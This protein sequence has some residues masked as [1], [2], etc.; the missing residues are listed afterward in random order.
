LHQAVT[1]TFGTPSYSL[2]FSNFA[3]NYS[4]SGAGDISNTASLTLNGTANV[5]LSGANTPYIAAL[6]VNAGSLYLNTPAENGASVTVNSGGTLGGSASVTAPVTVASGG[7]LVAG[8]GAGAGALT[9]SS[10]ALGASGTDA[11]T[12]NLVGNA[13]GL[14]TSFA[15]TTANGFANKGITTINVSGTLPGVTATN[16]N[17][18][19]YSG[20]VGGSG[21]FVLGSIPAFQTTAYLSNNVAASAIQLVIPPPSVTWVGAPTNNWDLSGTND[22]LVSSVG[23][24]S[25]GV[26][27]SYTNGD[28]VIF[29]DTA[30]NFSVNL[31]AMVKPFSVTFSNSLNNY[32]VTGAGSVTNV[33]SFNMN[34]AATTTFNGTNLYF[35]NLTVNAG[36]LYLN[37]LTNSG[38]TVTVNSGATLAGNGTISATVMKVA[39]GGALMAGSNAGSGT[40]IMKNLTLGAAATDALTLNLN[41]TTGGLSGT[42]TVTGSSTL[43]NNGVTTINI[44]GALPATYPATY[45]VVTYAGTTKGSGTFVLGTVPSTLSTPYLTNNAAALAIQLVVPQPSLTW[46]GTPTNNW[47]LTG[48]NVW[49]QTYSG[50]PAYFTNGSPVVF[51]DTAAS[52]SV[53][54]AGVVQPYSVVFSNSA[55]NYNFT[56]AGNVSNALSFTQMRAGTVTFGGAKIYNSFLTI[57]AGTLYLNTT[58]TGGTV[59][60]NRGG[61]LGGS[62]LIGAPVTVANGGALVAGNSA[63]AGILAMKSLVLG[64]SASDALTLNL[65]STATGLASSFTVT[66]SSG[67]TNNGIATINITGALPTNNPATY[68]LVTY[69][70]SVKGSGT[71]VLGSFP[72]AI[73][74]PYLTNNAS[75][76]AIQLVVPAY[77]APALTWVGSPTNDWDLAGSLDWVLTG[78]STPASYVDVSPLLFDDTATNFSVNLAGTV[79]PYT[80]VFT[81]FL[82]NYTVGGAGGIA[83]AVSLVK[84]GTATVTLATTNSYTG[85]TTVAAGTLALGSSAAIPSGPTAGNVVVNGTLDLAGNSPVVNNLS[86]SGTV[87]NLSAGGNPVLTVSNIANSSFS[88]VIQNSSGSVALAKT[89]PGTLT[90]A[91]NSTYNGG[92]TI[93]NG[94]VSI[95]GAGG[96]G[97]GPVTVTENTAGGVSNILTVATTSAVVLTNNFILPNASGTN[98]LTKN[99]TGRLTLGGTL[100]GGGSGMIL[101][102]STDTLLDTNTVTEFA[103]TNSFAG[104]VQLWRG[105]VQVDNPSSLGSATI[106]GNGNASTNGDLSFANSMTFANPLVMQA[107]TTVSPNTN[108]VVMSGAISGNYN[109]TKYGSGALTLAGANTYSGILT[110][111]AGTLAVGSVTLAADTTDSSQTNFISIAAGAVVQSSGNL[112]LDASTTI[113]PSIVVSGAGTLQLTATNNGPTSPDIYFNATDVPNSTANWGTRIATPVNLG[114]VQRYIWGN[115]EHASVDK[116]GVN[117]GD[118]QFNGTISGT[119]GL[120]FIAQ[121]SFTGANPMETPFCL[122]AANNFTGPVQIQRGSIYLGAAGAYPAGNVL[123][124]NV[125]AGNFGKLYLFGQNATV[126]DLSSTGAGGAFIANGCRN[127]S[128]IGP[129]TLTIIQNNPGTFTGSLVDTNLE[130][131]GTAVN[132][133]TILNVVKTGP[134]ALTL[135]GNHSFSGTLAVNAGKLYINGLS[136]GGGSVTVSNGA[137]LGGL[138]TITS[139]VT[140]SNAATLEAGGGLGFGALSLNKLTLGAQVSDAITLNCDAIPAGINEVSVQNANGLINN[141]TVTVNVTGVL[142][143]S[144]P[145]VYTLIAYAGTIQGAGSFVLGSVPDQ[146]VAYITNNTAAAA[147]Q[148]VVSSLTIPSVTWTGSPTNDWDLL[149]NN[150]WIQTGTSV[151]AAYADFDQVVFDDTATNFTVNL[152]AAVSPNGVTFSNNVNNYVINGSGAISGYSALTM[153]GT[154]SVTLATTNSYLGA[155]TIGAGTVVLGVS[156]AIPGGPGAGNL[157]VNGTLDVGGFS[158][159]FNNLSGAGVV[160]NVSAGGSPVLTVSN[161]AASVFAG[162]LQNTTGSLALNQTGSGTLVLA[163]NNTY[164]GITT[165]NSGAVQIGNGGASG[166]LGAGPVLDNGTLILDRSDLY[167][168]PNNIAGAG[169]LQQIG[170]GTNIVPGNLTYT[171][172]TVV[173]AGTLVYPKDV[174]FDAGTGTTLTVGSNAVVDTG[175]EILL[176]ANAA[177]NAVDISGAGIVRLVSRIDNLEAYADIVFGNNNNGITKGNYGV[178]IASGLD[179]GSTNRLIWGLSSLDDV[180]TYGLNGCDCQFSGPIYGT[181]AKVQLIG[182][183]SWKGVNTMEVQFAFNA[184]NSWTGPLE[185]TRGSVYVGNS[186]AFNGNVLILDPAPSVNSRFFLYGKNASVSAL[187]SG[188]FGSTVIANGN[189]VSSTNVGPAT[190]TVNEIIPT[191]FAGTIEDWFTEYTAPVTG[192][193]LPTLSLVVNGPAALTLTGTNTYSGTTVINAG[194]LNI[195][196]GSLG[197]GAVTVNPNATLGGSGLLASAVTVKNGGVIDTGT[198]GYGNFQVRS[199]TLGAGSG[200]AATLNLTPAAILSV[201]NINGLVLNGG[202]ASVTINLGGDVAAVGAV[203]LI[204]YAG[205]LGG[206]GF[207]AFQLGSVPPGVVGYLTNDTV[208]TSV[209]FVA[210]LVTVPRWSGALS[211]VWTTNV[212]ASPKNWILDSDGV[213]P[214]DYVD[215]ENVK[216]DDTATN[217]VVNISVATVSPGSV[218]ISNN[219]QNYV[220]SGSYGIAAAAS[221]TKLGAGQVLLGTV[222]TYPGNTVISAGTLTLGAAG[223]IPSGSAAGSVIVNGLLDVAGF[224]PTLNNLSG[225]GT[226]DN[227][228]AGGSPVLVVNSAGSSTFGGVMQNTTGSLGLTVTGSGTLTL[229]GTNTYTGPTVINGGTLT[230]NGSIAAGGLTAQPGAALG[231]TGTINGHVTLANGSGLNL[232]ANTPLEVGALTLNGTVTLTALGNISTTTSATYVLLN[233]T[234]INATNLFQLA[235][236]PGLLSSGYAATLNV[237]TNQLQLVIGPAKPTGTIADI[238]HIVFFTQENRS[239][240]HYFGTL[241]GVHGF[242]DHIT[243]TFT[244]GNSVLYQKN[245]ASY[246][247][248]FHTTIQSI[249]DLAHSWSDAHG[250]VDNGWHDGWVANK[251]TESMAYYERS[252]IPYHYALADA[253]TVCDEFHCCALTSTDPNRLYVFTGMIDPNGTAGYPNAGPVTANTEPSS[254]WGTNWLT[255][256]QVLQKAGVSWKVYQASDN[257]DDNANAWF[258]AFKQAATTSPLYMNGLADV[259]SIS[260]GFAADVANNTLATVSWIVG[261]DYGSEHPAYEPGV[262][263]NFLQLMLNAL[264]A[265]TNVYANTVFVYNIDEGDGFY[266]HEIPILPPAGTTNEFVTG[267]PIGLGERVPCVIVSP[268]TRG[269]YVCSQ[270]FDH[271]SVLRLMEDVTGVQCPN[272]SAWRRQVCG[273]LTNVFDFKHPSNDFPLATLNAAAEVVNYSTAGTTASPPGTQVVPVQEP[274]TL[275]ARPLPYQPNAWAALDCN[276]NNCNIVLTNS[277]TASYHFTIYPN[278]SPVILPT[279][280]DVSS[281][282]STNFT[283]STLTTSGNYNFSCYGPNGFLRQFAGNLKADCGQIEALP[284]LNPITEGFKIALANPGGVPTVFTITNGWFANSLATYTVPGNSTNVVFVDASTNVV[285]TATN[286]FGTFTNTGW[287]DLTVTASSDSLF[288]RRFAGHIETSA[289]PAGIISSENPSGFKDLVTFTATFAGYGIPTGT[290]QFLTNGVA[291][292]APVVLNNGLASIATALLPRTNNLVSVVYSGDALNSSVTNSLTQVVLNH[293]PVPTTVVYQRAAS[294]PLEILISDLLTNVTDVDGDPIT[295]V[296][297]GTDGLNLQ[298][299][300]GVTLSTDSNYIYYTN[301]VMPNVNDSFEYAVSD[302]QGGVSLGTIM[303]VVNTNYVTPPSI[304]VILSTTNAVVNFFGVPGAQYEVDRSTNLTPGLGMGWVPISTNVAPVSGI[305]QVN[306]TFQNLGI[307]TPPTPP[308]SYYR[309]RPNP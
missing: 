7:S 29:D 247:L 20:T 284:Y 280:I 214:I 116:Y 111:A 66:N 54:L 225:T 104:G 221:L 164:S 84:Q 1:K 260:N 258:Y 149:G 188:G 172:P 144:Y 233:Y 55:N 269:G 234:A 217:P 200:D 244:N 148:L 223:A 62:G 157:T 219:V 304:P 236:I 65:N 210:T 113:N 170:S 121:D 289:N 89:G 222:N 211:S 297:V 42:F 162:L 38:A 143:A 296:G 24:R 97:S 183:N 21:S 252:D 77:I 224:S 195:Y 184:S 301:S 163:S 27:T 213:T 86:G 39:N 50:A 264:A 83:G 186:N 70:G 23:G 95:T 13:S 45:N 46:V 59:T 305:I 283:F 178:C 76:L 12:L 256:A 102:V 37:N 230:V 35:T 306:D 309:L 58:N 68:N 98:V 4:L 155:T 267:A 63:G 108:N 190:L 263:A 88:G 286:L 249:A 173:N 288:V 140:V 215:G 87:D 250:E 208:H 205:T 185:I 218:T 117:E 99:Q 146:A 179:V 8:N 216:F 26:P 110:A 189:N 33:S 287:Y 56:G 279:P 11:L 126:S 299:T 93:A 227:V 265:N 30:S 105:V 199:L 72:T 246:E 134:A 307:Q 127:P 28:I 112:N 253:F 115:T 107:K 156:G 133:T 276:L 96:L 15:V 261:P 240:D 5:T 160:D 139:A 270:V 166:T 136:T 47:D 2:V 153:S 228:S 64:A 282:T 231:G 259:S 51:D 161:S 17:L 174:T 147:V 274:G 251:G 124:F 40:L 245:G 85:N 123:Q 278:G 19:T 293:P 75:A 150:D 3:N 159:T 294:L 14:A 49:Q 275:I 220:I 119:G 92:T 57:N 182:Q 130:Y 303:I 238:R 176:N 122:N 16:Y 255:Y 18:L 114:S 203:P 10:L 48:S 169:G 177:A 239:F 118:C 167:T 196:G 94:A 257:Y 209:D 32:T 82:N 165:I 226:V 152:A 74:P 73:S 67:L 175:F 101:R 281:A 191:T 291:L 237:A 141:A 158:P 41:S 78:T 34:G 197:G 90:L 168:F 232:T 212:L 266:D 9:M 22:W 44:T 71:F 262:G 61:T 154:G 171:G 25:S 298:T 229:T 235:P 207:A 106:I 193:L 6:T 137:T 202:A 103:G 277:G 81:N 31:A 290:A 254:G 132:A 273:D 100:S 129:A 128:G 295:L 91:A 201:T 125:A 187:Q 181:T 300:N 36:T 292:G 79:Q 302:G 285:G 138:G 131:A 194:Q 198:A 80:V 135:S 142:P 180:T 248:P 192:P 109:L 53:N 242:S 204:T 145:A 52:F 271:T 268:W 243:E 241:H 120:T 272:L 151:P 69:T 43:T 206:S 308:A 60:V